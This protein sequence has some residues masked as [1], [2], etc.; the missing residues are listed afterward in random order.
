MAVIAFGKPHGENVWRES[1]QAKRKPQNEVYDKEN[2]TLITARLAPSSMNNQPW[3]FEHDEDSIL[4]YCKIQ[5]FL[6]KWM[7]SQN[8]IDIGIALGNIRA[9]S[10]D[11]HFS[12]ADTHVEKNGYT[13]MD[14]IRFK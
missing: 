8:R 2:E 11:F 10:E 4:V 5:G 13:L 1:G 3:Y 9:V 14:T 6:K 12:L 7:V